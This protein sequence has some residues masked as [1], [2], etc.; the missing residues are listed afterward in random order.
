L[1]RKTLGPGK[2]QTDMVRLYFNLLFLSIFLFSCA[3]E[4]KNTVRVI[5]TGNQENYQHFYLNL[6]SVQVSFEESDGRTLWYEL[7]TTEGLKDFASDSE[8]LL[9]S[10]NDFHNG[11]I[12]AVRFLFKEGN[13][14]QKDGV[15]NE[16]SN[17]VIEVTTNIDKP[18]NDGDVDVKVNFELE[19][20]VIKVER[21]HT[22][23]PVVSA[24]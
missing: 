16:I 3:K 17:S 10:K 18:V 13:Y 7:Q 24:N 9:G 2:K 15:T 14:F 4:E 22:M 20:S 19:K 6:A 11:K 23:K 21:S 5:A 8:W 12:K 1:A